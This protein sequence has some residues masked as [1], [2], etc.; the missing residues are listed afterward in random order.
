MKMR[1]IM[2]ASKGSD[3]WLNSERSQLRRPSSELIRIYLDMKTTTSKCN[4]FFVYQLHL[5]LLSSAG[6]AGYYS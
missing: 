6:V 5:V 2:V 1:E 4:G 3:V